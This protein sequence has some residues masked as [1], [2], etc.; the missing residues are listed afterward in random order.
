M[1]ARTIG[2]AVAVATLLAVPARAQDALVTAAVQIVR[3]R[4][5]NDA[6][7]NNLNIAGS[8]FNCSS[9]AFVAA[10]NMGVQQR[11]EDKDSC[12]KNN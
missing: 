7:A 5:N 10:R 8:A 1:T 4:L 2:L 9:D 11:R 3:K 6:F 12:K